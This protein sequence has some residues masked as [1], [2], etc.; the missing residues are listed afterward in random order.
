M[1]LKILKTIKMRNL[2]GLRKSIEI[3]GHGAMLKI[4]LKMYHNYNLVFNIFKIKKPN[5]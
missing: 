2:S 1:L 5:R 3:M 4:E